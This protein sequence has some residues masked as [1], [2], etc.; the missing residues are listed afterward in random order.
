MENAAPS[1]TMVRIFRAGPEPD[2][3]HRGQ[4]LG[5]RVGL[6]AGLEIGREVVAFDADLAQLGCDAGDHPAE[7]GGARDDDGLGV[8]CGEG[9]RVVGQVIFP[10]LLV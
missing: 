2:A 7:R 8:E 1:P 9:L 10:K 6:Q 3:G 4:D 5:K